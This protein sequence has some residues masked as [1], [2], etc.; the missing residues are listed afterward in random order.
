MNYQDS[1]HDAELAK[2]DQDGEE[3]TDAEWER[4]QQDR[5]WDRY[6]DRDDA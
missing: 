3:M 6:M 2:G 5:D 4:Q 1:N